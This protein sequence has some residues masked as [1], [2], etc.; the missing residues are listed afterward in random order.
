MDFDTN[1]GHPEGFLRSGSWR[2]AFVFQV[3]SILD[4]RIEIHQEMMYVFERIGKVQ[5]PLSGAGSIE[6]Y[7]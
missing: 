2:P 3:Q 6:I 1:I 7:H 5:G 4:R